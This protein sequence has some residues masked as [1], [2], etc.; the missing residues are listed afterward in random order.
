[1]HIEW[2]A[3][4]AHLRF[5][6]EDEQENHCIEQLIS[7]CGNSVAALIHFRP[8]KKHLLEALDMKQSLADPRAFFK[9]FED[10][11]ALVAVRDVDDNAIAGAPHWNKWFEDG[12]KKRFGMTE[13]G[14]LKKCSGAWCEWKTDENGEPRVVAAMPKL[15]RQ[16][17]ECAKKAIGHELKGSSAPATPGTCLEKNPE[18]EEAIME[19][20]Q[21]SVV[22]KSSCLVAKLCVEGSDSV[23]QLAKSFSNPG[24]EQQKA[25][26]RFVGCL[27]EN[28][29]DIELTCRKPKEPRIASSVDSNCAT[30]KGDRRSA[31]GG[32]HALGG[33][34][35]SW[36]CM[37]QKSVTL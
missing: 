13:L 36:H 27:K 10:K 22:G 30:D 16:T 25:L 12:V 31:S 23:R 19:T 33:V 37:T 7:M 20:E 29:H 6:A 15:V 3:G 28:E 26:E 17:I 35:T 18:D 21:R 14:A 8:F 11:V 5:I 24:E 34:N 9:V 32:P 4:M 2:P 1:M